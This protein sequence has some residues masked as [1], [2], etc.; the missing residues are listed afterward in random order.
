[1]GIDF[2]AS[3]IE[4]Y[5]HQNCHFESVHTYFRDIDVYVMSLSADVFVLLIPTLWTLF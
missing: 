1:M 3:S 2:I 5:V 4:L